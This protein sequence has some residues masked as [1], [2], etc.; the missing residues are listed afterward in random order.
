MRKKTRRFKLN[1]VLWALVLLPPLGLFLLW[2][3]PR[4]WRYKTA[5]TVAA[6][7]FYALLAG[8]AWKAGFY[9]DYVEPPVPASGYCIERNQRG[10]Y[11]ID[12]VLPFER[13]IFQEV[14]EQER[15]YTKETGASPSQADSEELDDPE[16][17]A[18]TTVADNHGMDSTEVLAIFMKVSSKMVKSK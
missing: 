9:D 18:I 3:A 5:L 11:R 10:H 1:I 12:R 8:A 2:R 13:E 7:L 16:S 17:R 15:K 6:F 14:V 4:S